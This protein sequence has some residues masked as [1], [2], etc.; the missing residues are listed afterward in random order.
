MGLLSDNALWEAFG[1]RALLTAPYGGA[2]FGEC[3]T[4]VERV[5]DG[6]GDE[7]HRE[8]TATAERLT[9]VAG[10]SE[11]KGHTVSAAEAYLRACNYHRVAYLPLFG[12][13]TDPRALAS[14][15]ANASAFERGAA[16]LPHPLQV[17]EIPFGDGTLPAYLACADDSGEARP[18]LVQT[19]GYDGT[20][21]EMYFSHAA[22]ALRRGYN[23]LGFDGPGQGRPLVRDGIPLRPDWETV[24]SPV[25][26]HVLDLPEVDPDRVVLVGWSLGGYLAPRAA[27]GESRFAALIA[28]PGQWDPGPAM[29]SRLA[30]SDDDKAAFPDIDPAKLA[31]MEDW[32]RSDDADPS[33]RWRLL[34]RAPWVHGADTLLGALAEFS[35]FELSSVAGRIECPALLTTAEGDP[36]SAGAAQLL[37]AI[38]SKEKVLVQF[39]AAEGA[40]G[41]CEAMARTLYHQRVFDWLDET[42]APR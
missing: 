13:P 2:D 20:V 4:T 37:D 26:D 19:N 32:L 16:L 21:Q 15:E 8:W 29:V 6:G 10:A 25:L 33:L 31:P 36:T 17:L 7:W 22:A 3:L 35:K 38:A 41:H 40:G 27:A 24:V 30:L 28:D 11:T 23:W 34:D 39:T 1:Q 14:Y 12:A 42:L 18:T 9:E 5:G